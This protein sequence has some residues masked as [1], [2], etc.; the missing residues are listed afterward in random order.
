MA[1][2]SEATET[3]IL[4]S[5]KVEFLDKGFTSASLRTI[6]AN[7]GLTTGAMY[8]HF[9]DKDALF[10]ALVDDAIDKTIE[11][12]KAGGLD[13][14]KELEEAASKEHTEDEKRIL[15]EFMDFIYANF[16]AFTLLLTKSAGSTHQNF[17]EEICNLY[18]ESILQTITW[19]KSNFNITK[20]IDDMSI[21]ILANA[22]VNAYA[23]IV[24]HKMEKE[25][26]YVFMDNIREFFHF[27][28]MHMLGL[29]CE[30]H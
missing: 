14:H 8:R 17:L 7:A 29:P 28:F 13:A 9:K 19:M 23:E 2:E 12:I 11:V 6:A 26:A 20:K 10:C 5:A 24:L 30:E 3:K 16:D 21:H 4:Q 18:T 27:G 25:E 1:E 15:M 22:T